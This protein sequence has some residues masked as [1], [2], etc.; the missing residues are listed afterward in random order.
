VETTAPTEGPAWSAA[1]A[2]WVEY[3]AGFAAPAGEAVALAAGIE[4]AVSLLD[5]GGSGEFCELAAGRGARL[6]GSDA[7]A[8]LIEF[9]RH[10]LP[11]AD[12]RVGAI[13]DLPWPDT[14]FD[15]VTG[16][17]AFQ[18]APDFV[19]ALAEARRVTRSGGRVRS[20]TGAGWRTAR[21]M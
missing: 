13:E 1:A 15:V 14:S 12:L 9:A 16:I 7:A 20:A 11:E 4:A 18:F 8:G 10:R 17:N 2:G 3:W 5:V 21:C 6:S 19:A